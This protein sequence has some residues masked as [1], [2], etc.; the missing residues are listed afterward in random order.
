M[1]IPI[2]DENDNIIRYKERDLLKD[3]DTFRVSAL[4]I[5]NS[6]GEILLSRRSLRKK[7]GAGKWGPAVAGTVEE[8]ETYDANIMKEA[9]E[10]LG[11]I[12][13]KFRKFSK[14][15]IVGNHKFFCQWYLLTINKKADDFSL[16]EGEVE[17][18]KWTSK[19]ELIKRF[20]SNPEEF[21]RSMGQYLKLLVLTSHKAPDTPE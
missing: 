14:Q 18:I 15:R 5:T 2:V 6:R 21:V 11:I 19:E 10:E 8:S 12:N 7:S 17:E 20:N 4:W 1:R 16:Q 3:D 13:T 9:R